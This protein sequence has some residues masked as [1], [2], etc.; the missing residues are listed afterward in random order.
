MKIASYGNYGLHTF[1]FPVGKWGYVGIV[2]EA[3]LNQR[4]NNLGLPIT[5]SKLFDT[6]QEAINYFESIKKD[7]EV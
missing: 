1:K 3:L 7:I 2:P 4:K 5:V 6:E